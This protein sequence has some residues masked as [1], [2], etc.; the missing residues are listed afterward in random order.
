MTVGQAL[1]E[2]GMLDA[3]LKE[4]GISSRWK[5]QFHFAGFCCGRSRNLA[6][7]WPSEFFG[8]LYLAKLDFMPKSIGRPVFHHSYSIGLQGRSLALYLQV[9]RSPDELHTR[10]QAH[11]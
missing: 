9:W 3:H 10:T 11:G 1:L 5:E 2:N 6:G 8:S 4:F 7:N